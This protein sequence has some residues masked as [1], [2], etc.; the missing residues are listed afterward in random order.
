MVQPVDPAAFDRHPLPDG[1]DPDDVAA[2]LEA[3]WRAHD[4]TSATDACDQLLWAV[5]DNDAGTF[6]PV[7]LAVLPHLGQV[8]EKAGPW[9]QHAAIE[10]L[11]DLAGTFAPAEGHETHEGQ[12]VREAVRAFVKTLR[13]RLVGIAQAADG[14]SNGA[15]ELLEL[16]DDLE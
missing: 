14:R 1:N 11:I 2:A 5:G 4:G 12:A 7:V 15:S 13:P 9:A 6:H 8:L 3:V 16:I 10:A